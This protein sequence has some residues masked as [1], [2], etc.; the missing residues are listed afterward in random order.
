MAKS[1]INEFWNKFIDQSDFQNEIKEK[2]YYSSGQPYG[3]DL[4]KI[5]KIKLSDG[6][7]PRPEEDINK[8]FWSKQPEPLKKNN[9][10]VMR[11]G[12]GK[13][14]IV[15]K[16]YYGTCYLDLKTDNPDF[17]LHPKPNPSLPNLEKL[18]FN[19]NNE[20]TIIP[21][22]KYFGIIRQI[23]EILDLGT[24]YYDGPLVRTK[25]AFPAYLINNS[26]ESEKID[27]DS[28][29][30]NDYTIYC[31][32]TII[33]IELKKDLHLDLGWHKLAYP[34]MSFSEAIKEKTI[35]KIIPMYIFQDKNDL[36]IYAFENFKFYKDGIELNNSKHMTHTKFFKT[37]LK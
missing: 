6:K 25:K 19:I 15:S 35:K 9:F 17:V 20:K 11:T 27:I 12:V 14:V 36:Y 23:T 32:N 37:T 2:G 34:S 30:E 7:K 8:D 24:D 13:F 10:Y 16:D 5:L 4:Y 26:L 29:I 28:Q 31:D 3:R 33:L 22:M 1:T 21:K 18:L